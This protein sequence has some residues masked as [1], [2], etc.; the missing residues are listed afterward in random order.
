M[1]TNLRARLFLYGNSGRQNNES[2]SLPYHSYVMGN[3]L[4]I[5]SRNIKYKDNIK[6]QC[7]KCKKR[8][9]IHGIIEQ[10]R[11]NLNLTLFFFF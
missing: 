10:G 9:Q 8:E 11:L 2:D 6:F 7:E 1:S 4:H 5:F 3:N